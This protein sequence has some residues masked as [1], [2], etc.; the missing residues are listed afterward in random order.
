LRA[1]SQC[2][3]TVRLRLIVDVTAIR[4][5]LSDNHG[6]QMISPYLT[7]KHLNN[8]AGQSCDA[9]QFSLQIRVSIPFDDRCLGTV[10]SMRIFFS[11]LGSEKERKE[12]RVNESRGPGRLINPPLVRQPESGR[13]SLNLG[14]FARSGKYSV[15]IRISIEIVGQWRLET[16][17]EYSRGG[18]QRISPDF[19]LLAC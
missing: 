1:L 4:A 9:A 8:N 18:G 6:T 10:S 17:P 16:P 13:S 5:D 3:S 15:R 12:F 7:V 19:G 14:P 2:I 11:Q